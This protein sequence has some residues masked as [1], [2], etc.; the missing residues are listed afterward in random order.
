M[1][2][3]RFL[4]YI[5]FNTQSNEDSN[6]TPSTEG[7][8]VLL[9]ELAAEL[10]EIGMSNIS[11]KPENGYVMATLPT[12]S[13]E[14][15]PTIGFIAHIDTSPDASGENIKAKS[16]IYDGTDIL[17]NKEQN[18]FLSEKDFPEMAK[19]KGQELLV[20][21]GTT[22]LGA[23]DKAGV[24]E[25]VTA[26]E[27]FIQHPEKKHGTIRIAFTTDEEIGRGTDK[28]DVEEFN[29]DW[30]Y[31]M[32]GGEI[33]ELEYENFNAAAATIIFHGRNIHPGYAKGKMINS[34][35][36][37]R[38][39]SSL[40]PSK[41]VPEKTEGQ[42][43]FYHLIKMEGKIEGSKLN[44]IIRDHDRIKFE[45]RKLNMREI[46]THLQKK[47]GEENIQLEIKDQY[48]NMLEKIEPEM[49]IIDLAKRAMLDCGVKPKVQP[50]R[51]GT[52]GAML[53]FKGLPCPNLFAG[54]LN[55]H[56]RFEFIP[57]SSMEA[58][59]NVIIRICTLVK[60]GTEKEK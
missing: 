31:T 14:E 35:T 33:G 5:G 42:E 55:F 12:N 60:K 16:V 28:F 19:Y 23:D 50:I 57:V 15:L 38:E 11:L 45:R 40:L 10:K 47:Y 21:D 46:C 1:V 43:G 9:K 56:G 39:F 44:Y 48:Y 7:Q 27:H 26:M 20:T 29:A 37:A 22:L 4:K 8:T 2:K 6:T 24:A 3:E 36:V 41:E 13:D 17:L 32:D 52:D 30:A 34:M 58:A 25:I 53:S 49:H 59:V 54:G 51:G 18:I